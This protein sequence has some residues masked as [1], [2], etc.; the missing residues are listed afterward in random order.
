MAM[1]MSD[2]WPRRPPKI[3]AKNFANSRALFSLHA[4]ARREG[5]VIFTLRVRACQA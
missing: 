4:S 3:K 2:C 5:G 1:F